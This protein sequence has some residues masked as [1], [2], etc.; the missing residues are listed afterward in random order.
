MMQSLRNAKQ[1]HVQPTLFS[2]WRKKTALKIESAQ[3]GMRCFTSHGFI[4][5]PEFS[6]T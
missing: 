5:F 6:Y 3:D 1:L 2:H 4:L